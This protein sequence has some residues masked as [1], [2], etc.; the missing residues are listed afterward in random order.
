MD[1]R[2]ESDLRYGPIVFPLPDRRYGDAEP[3]GNVA[4]QEPKIQ[5]TLAEPVA[6]RLQLSWISGI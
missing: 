4:L 5:S 6:E 2:H 3:V 1:R